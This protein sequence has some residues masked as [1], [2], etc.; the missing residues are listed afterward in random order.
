M[1]KKLNQ[2]AE[3]AAKNVSRRGFLGSLGRSAIAAA[4]ALGAMLVPRGEAAAGRPGGA[5]K[6]PRGYQKCKSIDR[7]YGWYFYCV[8][9]GSSC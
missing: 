9:R 7:L 2:A 6:C 1:L 5:T 8:P 3:H 4:G